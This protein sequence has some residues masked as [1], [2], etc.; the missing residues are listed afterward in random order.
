MDLSDISK[1]Y[2][3]KQEGS[4]PVRDG[5]TGKIKDVWHILAAV[6]VNVGRPTTRNSTG[7]PAI[8]CKSQAFL[9]LIS[10]NSEWIS[11]ILLSYP[12][13]MLNTNICLFILAENARYQKGLSLSR[14]K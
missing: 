12:E 9:L 7:L 11:L 10:A 14:V 3:E 2:S 1:E 13:I 5:S 8:M 4:S 6:G